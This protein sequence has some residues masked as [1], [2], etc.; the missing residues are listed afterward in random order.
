MHM[1]VGTIADTATVI[2]GSLL[3]MLLGNLR[4]SI[5]W[6]TVMK[7]LGL[8]TMFIGIPG[9]L[10]GS[11]TL[12]DIFS[13]VIGAVI[14]ELRPPQPLYQAAGGAVF[15]GRSSMPPWRRASSPPGSSPP[16]WA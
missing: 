10:D 11:N 4:S 9:M 5:L 6:D 2:A 15:I 7:G 12:I 3:G 14:G 13:I 8:C 16:S 1:L